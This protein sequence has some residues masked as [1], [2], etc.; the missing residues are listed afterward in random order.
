MKICVSTMPKSHDEALR[1]IEKAE[2]HKAD[3]I[4]VRL[5]Q[6][7][8]FKSLRDIAECTQTPLIATVRTQE[9][10]GKFLGKEE[11]RVEILLNAASSGFKYVDI[12]LGAPLLRKVVKDLFPLGVKPIISFHDFEK[13]PEKREL[14][15]ILKS[16]IEEGADI[17]KIVT[18]AQSLQ[19]NLTLLQFLRDENSKAKIVCF[20][21]GSLGKLS[22]LL[23]PIYGGYFTIAS[24]ERGEETAAGQ[25]TIEKMRT[26]Y[27]I[28]GVM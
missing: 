6:L 11:K 5:D 14:Q 13:T 15:Q 12:E 2:Q 22:R 25:M 24:L 8:G 1:L 26:L 4:E 16:E 28:L 23:S 9:C 21:M 10:R 3:F 27:K 20:A 17:C 19:D 7:G 18:T